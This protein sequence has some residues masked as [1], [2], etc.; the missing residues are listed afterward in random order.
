MLLVQIQLLLAI[1]HRPNARLIIHLNRKKPA[2]I[3]P[4]GAT[5]HLN[6]PI[7]PTTNRDRFASNWILLAASLKLRQGDKITRRL[8]Q[9]NIPLLIHHHTLPIV[10]RRRGYKHCKSSCKSPLSYI[11]VTISQPPTNSPFTKS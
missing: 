6:S 1:S 10:N 9:Q 7:K 5:L 8:R 2:K 3:I 11:S 4:H